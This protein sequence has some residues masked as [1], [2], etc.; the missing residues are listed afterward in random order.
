MQSINQNIRSTQH[1]FNKF[2]QITDSYGC[3][4]LLTS[5]ELYET[6]ESLLPD[7]RECLFPPTETLSMFFSTGYEPR[8]LMPGTNRIGLMSGII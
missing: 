7:H 2:P 4:D 5:E 3:F 1:Q 6:T 8:W